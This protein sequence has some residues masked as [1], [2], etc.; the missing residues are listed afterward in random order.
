MRLFWKQEFHMSIPW[1]KNF[2]KQE[3]KLIQL[4]ENKLIQK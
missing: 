3:G 2:G 4:Q 1:F